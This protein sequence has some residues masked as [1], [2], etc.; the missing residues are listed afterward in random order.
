MNADDPDASRLQS[1]CEQARAHR[2][3]DLWPAIAARLH[4]RTRVRPALAAASLLAGAAVYLALAELLRR[5]PSAGEAALQPIVAAAVPDLV[6]IAA[7]PVAE[8]LLLHQLAASPRSN[9]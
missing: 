6:Q 2:A 1:L 8:H 7:E 9:R 5:Q 4:A 3:P